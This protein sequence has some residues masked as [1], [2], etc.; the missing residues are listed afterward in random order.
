MPRDAD[1]VSTNM[2][3]RETS[4][5]R[6]FGRR[7]RH[8]MEP[9]TEYRARRFAVIAMALAIMLAW[10]ATY[11]QQ[12]PSATHPKAAMGPSSDQPDVWAADRRHCDQ[13]GGAW[14]EFNHAC[15]LPAP[16]SAATA[17]QSIVPAG[18]MPGNNEL[19]AWNRATSDGS[20][21]AYIDFH[22]AYPDS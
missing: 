22:H 9:F 17:P 10:N 1:P 11:A 6:D 13:E 18:Q 20:P 15:R 12:Q 3:S 5:V 21:R 14:F 4:A 2:E 16:P 8:K 19:A 7:T